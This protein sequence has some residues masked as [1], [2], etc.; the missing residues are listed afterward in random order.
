MKLVKSLP[1]IAWIGWTAGIID[2]EGWIGIRVI[3]KRSDTT[4]G[5]VKFTPTIEVQNTDFP[6]IKKLHELWGGYFGEHREQRLNW[7]NTYRW[8]AG[9]N[10]LLLILNACLPYLIT[11]REQA[12]LALYFQQSVADNRNRF[13]GKA[14]PVDEMQIRHEMALQ[15]KKLNQRGA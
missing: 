2:G 15:M 1:S 7:K 13:W 14:L 11:K 10:T 5:N 6:M 8:I 12:E 4:S 3:K 9:S